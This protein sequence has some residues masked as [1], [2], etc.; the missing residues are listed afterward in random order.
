V[1]K[2]GVIFSCGGA[3]RM[4][5]VLQRGYYILGWSG[6]GG[7]EGQGKDAGQN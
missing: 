3:W 1:E 2:V 7:L 5:K 4:V 6:R